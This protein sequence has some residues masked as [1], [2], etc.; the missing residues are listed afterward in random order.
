ML[1]AGAYLAGGGGMGVQHPHFF[2][3]PSVKMKMVGKMIRWSVKF[4]L[5]FTVNK[6]TL[7]VKMK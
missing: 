7:V 3:K 5:L 2:G 4:Q 6:N 1:V